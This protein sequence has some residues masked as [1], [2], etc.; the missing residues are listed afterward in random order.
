[1]AQRAERTRTPRERWEAAVAARPL[2]NPRPLPSAFHAMAREITGRAYTPRFTTGPATRQALAAAGALGATTGTVVH[3]PGA[4]TT[5]PSSMQV[6]THE[7]THTRS[8]VRRPRFFLGGL[9]AHLDDDERGALAAGRSM[10]G[11]IPTGPTVGSGLPSGLPV[12]PGG[13]AGG[14]PSSIPTSMPGGGSL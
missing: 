12:A 1:A 13:M 6:L 9:T 3:L 8:P 5:A 2:E 4:P 10:L 14:I 7:L 11:G